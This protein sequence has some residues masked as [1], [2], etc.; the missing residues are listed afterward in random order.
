MPDRIVYYIRGGSPLV[1]DTKIS[2]LR[3]LVQLERPDHKLR[4]SVLLPRLLAV[5]GG[6]VGRMTTYAAPDAGANPKICDFLRKYRLQSS[7]VT[8]PVMGEFGRFGILA[9]GGR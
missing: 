3:L 2:H 4:K 1:E 9:D 7:P 8:P 6:Q 5:A